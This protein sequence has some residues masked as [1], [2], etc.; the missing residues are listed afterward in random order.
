M[1]VYALFLAIWRLSLSITWRWDILFAMY[2][3]AISWGLW[4]VDRLQVFWWIV[5]YVGRGPTSG[6]I[7]LLSIWAR[8]LSS[9]TTVNLE[10]Q[11]QSQWIF[12]HNKL[13]QQYIHKHNNNNKPI[14]FFCTSIFSRTT[15]TNYKLNNNNNKKQQLK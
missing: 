9:V 15:T 4:I 13:I 7:G 14:R 3:H 5:H 1:G 6:R 10:I 11:I 12:L 8:I 2:L